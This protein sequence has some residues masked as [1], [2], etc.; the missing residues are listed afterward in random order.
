MPSITGVL[1]TL[2]LGSLEEGWLLYVSAAAL[3]AGLI[4]SSVIGYT[5]S[6]LSSQLTAHTVCST[7]LTASHKFNITEVDLIQ[8]HIRWVVVF[9][10]A[11][12]T[13][14]GC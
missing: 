13:R 6:L 14:A 5:V 8:F 4:L 12:L 2:N 3:V 7:Q 9:P 10:E 11:G 1:S